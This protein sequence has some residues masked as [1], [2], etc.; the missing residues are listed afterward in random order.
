VYF[1]PEVDDNGGFAGDL[2]PTGATIDA[3]GGWWDAGDYLKFVETESYTV[4]MML[5][6]VR[7]FPKQMGSGS[8]TSDL[9]AEAKFGLDWLLKMWDDKSRTLYYQVGIGNGNEQTIS[10]HDLWRLPQADDRFED[11]SEL[12]RHICHRPVFINPAGGSG[13]KVSPNLAGAASFALCYQVYKQAKPAYADA[14]LLSAE[15]VFDLAD[16]D[17]RGNLLSVIPFSFYGET[18]WRDDLEWAATELYF[19]LRGASSLPSGLPHTTASFYLQQAGRWASA[20]IHGPNDAAD[21]L[22]LYT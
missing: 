6:G 18:E 19:A 13:A 9:T 21:T 15:H 2:Q 16:T 1:T 10:D 7:D 11:C 4:A 8:M 3:S 22:N 14:C 20:Y 12:Y 17:P 5:T